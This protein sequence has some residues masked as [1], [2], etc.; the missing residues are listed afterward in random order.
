MTTVLDFIR[1]WNSSLPVRVDGRGGRSILQS[2]YRG[3]GEAGFC[4]PTETPQAWEWP[5]K[6][7]PRACGR[8]IRCRNNAS[9]QSAPGVS[10]EKGKERDV[11]KRS[12][13]ILTLHYKD[14]KFLVFG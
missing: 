12:Q 11:R 9:G 13:P 7:R 5:Q 4:L 1:V 10:V 6:P 3:A 8:G 2:Q 14:L